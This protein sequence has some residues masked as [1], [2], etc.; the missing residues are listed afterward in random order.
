MVQKEMVCSMDECGTK[1][2][3]VVKRQEKVQIEIIWLQ[4]TANN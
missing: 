4:T 2:N 1:E 3:G